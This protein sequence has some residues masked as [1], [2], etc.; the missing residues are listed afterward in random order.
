MILPVQFVNE[1]FF[2]LHPYLAVITRIAIFYWIADILL[3]F[4]TGYLKKGSLE[5]LR[6]KIALNY[7]R[8]WLLPDLIVTIIDCVLEFS[9]SATEANRASTRVLRL[10]RLLRVVRLGKVT[11]FTAFL[12]DRFETKAR[13]R[14]KLLM[15]DDIGT[16]TAW[17]EH[18]V[19]EDMAAL[20]SRPDALWK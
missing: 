2:S 16:S 13:A 3:T 18:C 7:L 4:T 19:R 17:L 1:N 20:Q 14:F 12:R 10:L 6:K 8:S 5:T 9:S 11:R 15:K